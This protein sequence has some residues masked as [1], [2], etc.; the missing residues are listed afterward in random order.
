MEAYSICTEAEK[1][2]AMDDD[3][4]WSHVFGALY[5]EESWFDYSMA[6][7]PDIFAI[8]CARCGVK[9]EVEDPENRE[10]DAFCDECASELLPEIEVELWDQI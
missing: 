9:V 4:F 3:Q 6:F 2:A 8:D 10:R 1:R 7:E 5:D